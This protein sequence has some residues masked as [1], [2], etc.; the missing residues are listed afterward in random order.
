MKGMKCVIKS[1]LF[2]CVLLIANGCF[3][4]SSKR[5]IRTEINKDTTFVLKKLENQGY[6]WGLSV[7]I[8]ADFKDSIILSKSL[9]N[10]NSYE[11]ILIGQIDTTFKGD[12]YNDYCNLKFETVKNP[13]GEVFIEY[14]FFD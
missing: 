2:T 14:D 5:T 4:P 3:S 12:W 13:V 9:D 1:M 8:K 7:R 6:I 10:G 11:Y